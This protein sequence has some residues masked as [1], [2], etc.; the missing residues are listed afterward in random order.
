MK[1]DKAACS[2]EHV[3]Y[4]QIINAVRA[5]NDTFPKVQEVTGCGRGC[6]KCRDFIIHMI[7]DIKRFP[8][9]YE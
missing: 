9:D 4:G 3:T 7:G 8:A 6:G 5:G 2:C 1:R